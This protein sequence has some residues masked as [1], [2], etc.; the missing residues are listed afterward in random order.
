MT[1]LPHFDERRYLIPFRSLLLPHIFTD[2][3][4]IGSGVAGMRAALAAAEGGADVI[5]LA[6]GELD[7][8]CTAQAQGGIAIADADPVSIESHYQDTIDTGVGL[9]GSEAVR[10][11]VED[12]PAALEELLKWGMRFDRNE[13]G[14]LSYGREGAHSANRILHTDGAATGRE[15][16]RCLGEKINEA[17]NIRV[18]DHCFALDLMTNPA[19][20]ERGKQR[21]LGAITHHNQYGLQIIWAKATILAS[22]GAGQV[23]RESTN[24]TLT[25]GDGLAMAYR[26]G[27]WLGDLEFIQFH[28]TT[29]YVAGASRSLIS[30][31]VRGEGAKLVDRQDQRFMDAYHELAELAP[32]DVVSRAILDQLA[33]TQEAAVYLDVRH[34]GNGFARR[35]PNLDTIL[36][37][38]DID[39]MKNLIPVHPSAHYTIG[40]VCTDLFGRTSLPGLYACGEVAC[41]G[42]HG[43]NRLASNSLLEGLVY[44][45]RA[46]DAAREMSNALH[47]PMKIVSEMMTSEHGE[48]DLEDVRSSLRSTMW[49]NVGIQRTGAKLNDVIDMFG[50]WARYILD[51]IFDDPR[52]WETQNMLTVGVLITR[53]AKWR[54]E[55]RGTHYRTD[56][57]GTDDKFLLH[58]RWQVNNGSPECVSVAGCTPAEA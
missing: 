34:L 31:A 23:F 4:V 11:L 10:T 44:G 57:P 5:L 49:R 33:Q 50:F 7:V 25:T 20:E 54:E 27:A 22:G 58:A 30:E 37:S 3:L 28:P 24:P 42:L 39:P 43:A 53:A 32:R 15:L 21:V 12:G 35:F 1:M 47:T 29:L 19:Q 13:E 45:K 16:A 17:E 41:T 26:A 38:Y 6:K 8:S 36:K 51:S 18:F 40:G 48:L 55:S 52:G 46:G 9:C 2:T 14:E 56:C